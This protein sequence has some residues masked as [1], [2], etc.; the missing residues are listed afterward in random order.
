MS[1]RGL[2]ERRRRLISRISRHLPCNQPQ[3][4]QDFGATIDKVIGNILKSPNDLKFRELRVNNAMVQRRIIG[5][6]GG[7]EVLHLLGFERISKHG[8]AVYFLAEPQGEY[9]GEARAW[10]SQRVEE[11]LAM[12]RSSGAEDGRSGRPCADCVVKVKLTTGQVLEGGFYL[13]EPVRNIYEFVHAS[14]VDQG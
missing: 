6:H 12:I 8:E 3:D 14:I 4:V 1:N 7:R 5:C 11:C 13:Q 10:V 9:L 2:D